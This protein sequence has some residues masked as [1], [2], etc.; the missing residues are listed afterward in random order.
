MTSQGLNADGV[1]QFSH[2]QYAEA[3]TS[4]E[5]AMEADPNN[6]DAYYN[7]A[8]VFHRTGKQP[9]RTTDL[10]QAER[11][12]YLCLDHDPNHRECYRGLAVLLTE[13]NRGDDAARL[14]QRWADQNPTSA[15]PRIELA[16]LSEEKGDR[17]AAKQQLVNALMVDSQNSRA[18]A[19]LG[20]LRELDGERAQALDNYQRSLLANS[21]QPE[22]AARAATL[23]T[24]AGASTP[25]S[26]ATDP[27]RLATRNASPVW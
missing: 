12:Y 19:A 2:T 5:K 8:S 25:T 17:Q 4:F 26:T 23:Q 22:M 9:G 10:S 20:R 3:K 21:N 15:E 24:S 16:R 27:S 18:L 6:A 11:Y 7:L 14:L 1:R 13:Q